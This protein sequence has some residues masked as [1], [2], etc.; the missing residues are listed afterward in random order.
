MAY[1]FAFVSALVVALGSDVLQRL[2]G[3]DHLVLAQA[4]VVATALAVGAVLDWRA[5]AR[6]RKDG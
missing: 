6:R 5:M 3:A 1:A 2:V 4:G